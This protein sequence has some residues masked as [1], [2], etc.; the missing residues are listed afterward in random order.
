[1]LP[2]KTSSL[3]VLVVASLLGFLPMQANAQ[4]GDI[5]EKILEVFYPYRQGVPQ[6]EGITP[7]TEINKDKTM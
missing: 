3:E 2:R 1:M 4:D 5:R 6:V 7:G